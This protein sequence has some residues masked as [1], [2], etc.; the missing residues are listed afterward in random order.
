MPFQLPM[1]YMNV[2]DLAHFESRF[3]LVDMTKF[4]EV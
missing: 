2:N 1:A 4:V 3:L